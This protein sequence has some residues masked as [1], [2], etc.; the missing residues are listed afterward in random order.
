MRYDPKHHEFGLVENRVTLC[1]GS[2]ISQ[3]LHIN[4]CQMM[5]T[6]DSVW[7]SLGSRLISY[8]LV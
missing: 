3:M 2:Q 7:G 8:E 4:L 6:G 1:D 5:E